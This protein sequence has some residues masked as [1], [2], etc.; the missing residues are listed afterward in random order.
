MLPFVVTQEG[1]FREPRYPTGPFENLKDGE[2][3][4]MDFHTIYNDRRFR[5]HCAEMGRTLGCMFSCRRDNTSETYEVTRLSDQRDR[6]SYPLIQLEI[7]EAFYVPTDVES[8]EQA[9]RVWISTQGKKQGKSFG[10]RKHE[11]HELYEVF[12]KA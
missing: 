4:Y 10:V 8:G 12:R 3:F 1:K 6:K 11:E 9:F 7:G 2:C 5:L